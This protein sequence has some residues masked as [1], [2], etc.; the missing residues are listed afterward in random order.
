MTIKHRVAHTSI[1]LAK[2]LL[3]VS[4]FLP[5]SV[6]SAENDSKA[7]LELSL[8]D[9]L[10]VQVTTAT[11]EE[12]QIEDAP[13][14]ISV[15]TAS[16]LEDLSIRTLGEALSYTPGVSLI[17]QQKGDQILVIRG[18]ALKDG[19]LVLIDGSPVND[20]FDGN[21]VFFNRT[22]DDIERI[23]VLRG[24][25]SAL[26]GSYAVSGVIQIF[27]KRWQNNADSF[28][29]STIAGSFSEK[30][31]S[32]NWTPNLE[33]I[34][35]DLKVTTSFS[36]SDE[37][38]D[39]YFIRQDALF[40]PEQGTFLP[41]FSNPT[42]TPT[43]RN[44]PVEVFNGHMAMD[45]KNL[46]LTYVHSQ[47]LTNPILS[48]VG[49]VTE[50]DKTIKETTL[51]LLSANYRKDFSDRVDFEFNSFYS[52]NESKLFGQSEPP[53]IHGDEDQ[54][55]LNENFF[56]GIIES[57]HHQTRSI[58]FDASVRYQ[59]GDNHKLL[60]GVSQN[61]TKLTKAQ[62]YANVSLAGRGPTE[63]F[64]VQDLSNEFIEE[65]IERK[66]TAFYL[67]DNWQFSEDVNVTLGARFGDY[68]DF[69]S[70]S[71]P[72]L[73]INFRISPKLYSKFLYGEAFKPPAFAQLFDTT[74]TLSANRQ[75]G[76]AQ[77]KPTE[78]NSLEWQLGYDF[79]DVIKGRATVFHN[80]TSNEIFFDP[81][82]GIEQWQNSG[83][84]TSKGV[85]L[86]LKGQFLSFFDL[87]NFNYSYQ[88]TSGVDMGAGANIHS[89]HRINFSATK[90]VS[91]SLSWS[92]AFSYYSSPE[93]EAGDLRPRIDDMNLVNFSIKRKDLITEGLSLELSV[94]NLF[95]ESGRFETEE[96]LG[97]LDDLPVEG[98]RVR[99]TFDYRIQ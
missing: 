96:A 36:Y 65:G 87:S 79:S 28:A 11:K 84:R 74:P 69:G 25:S 75:R 1:Y 92:L 61:N 95:D 38:G 39:E 60:I 88:Q 4:L 68:N 12:Q 76:N 14:I 30:A 63:V 54:D 59:W 9:L 6:N 21:S 51:D 93:R 53:Q 80:E 10:K 66:E 71:D 52:L 73:G 31:L 81:T 35:S 20:A 26:Y 55:G 91:D 27:T 7:I 46:K 32:I 34:S 77:L 33:E 86:E 70:T 67:Q 42:L 24:P 16:E 49:V 5:H 48:H 22:V 62:K 44:K 64:P 29:V 98:R 41:P 15:I 58:G 50:V 43:Y 45:Y 85:E 2:S 90:S 99:L 47:E 82:P 56:S 57:F 40:T 97:L 89:P 17:E 72:R 13:S 8:A 19:V 18:L 23:E 83:E 37:E 78:I 3:L 94:K